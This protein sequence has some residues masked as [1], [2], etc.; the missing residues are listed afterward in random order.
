MDYREFPAL[1]P[2]DRL[3]DCVWFLTG[4]GDSYHPQP[5]VPDGRLE[6]LVHL[7]DP[8]LRLSADGS[9]QVQD[10]ILVA[11]QLTGPIHL[12]PGSWIDVVGVRLNPLGAFAVLALP[13][14]DL[15]NDVVSLRAVRPGLSVALEAAAAESGNQSERARTISTVLGRFVSRETEGGMTAAVRSLTGGYRGPL[16]SLAEHCGLTGKTLQR[17]FQNEVGLSPKVFQQVVRFR[18]AF[19]LLQQDENGGAGVA[20]TAGYYDQA[21]L[22]RDFKRFAGATPRKFFRPEPTLAEV[23]STA[24]HE[25]TKDIAVS[26]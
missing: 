16:R 6:L 5:V 17:R 14:S 19:R 22:I 26:I 2:L 12:Q 1:P 4:R 20:A 3:I 18:R 25:D 15:T 10:S 9:T 11:G 24:Y 13:L 7:G 23:F 21:H 8:F